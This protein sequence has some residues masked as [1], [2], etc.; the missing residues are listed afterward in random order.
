M[1]SKLSYSVKILFFVFCTY[2]TFYAKAQTPFNVDWACRMDNRPGMVSNNVQ[3][4]NSDIMDHGMRIE[5]IVCD[6]SRPYLYVIENSNLATGVMPAPLPSTAIAP[7]VAIF[8]D[9]SN[10][11]NVFYMHVVYYNT[12][13]NAYQ[14]DVFQYSYG[15]SIPPTL[16][17]PTQTI[18]G[19]PYAAPPHIDVA[20]GGERGAIT[21]EDNGRIYASLCNVSTVGFVPSTLCSIDHGTMPD[22]AV[23]LNGDVVLL[24]Y[25][26]SSTNIRA[27]AIYNPNLI[28]CNGFSMTLNFSGS[29]VNEPRIAIT[30][31]HTGNWS[32]VWLDKNPSNITNSVIGT[33]GTI[34]IANNFI[35]SGVFHDYTDASTWVSPPPSSTNFANCA[36][37]LS[38]SV[39]NPVLSFNNSDELQV[40]FITTEDGAQNRITQSCSRSFGIGVVCDNTG[41]PKGSCYPYAAHQLISYFFGNG[42][43][44][45][46]LAPNTGVTSPEF[47][48]AISMSGKNSMQNEYMSTYFDNVAC[49]LNCTNEVLYK[50]GYDG[51][52]G[53]RQA[54]SNHIAT[55]P[56]MTRLNISPNPFTEN[57]KI[58]STNIDAVC[59]LIITDISGRE[60]LN[61]NGNNEQLNSALLICNAK[62]NA[63]IYFINIKNDSGILLNQKIVKQ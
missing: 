56:S 23:G 14:L 11:S 4:T 37:V 1:T 54:T 53:F 22:V 62:L 47:V 29:Q 18:F 34:D 8:N 33:M 3:I 63:G 42:I 31:N 35:P 24:S 21:I 9:L 41:E 52:S 43:C 44:Q 58:T 32:I 40:G 49:N 59:N 45:N 57:I 17:V 51:S 15:S 16:A 5:A 38:S 46:S 36:S 39:F 6:G 10:G 20:E 19:C 2:Y 48:S 13:V 28:A 27:K 26:T 60:L 55:T 7:D 12:A 50:D 30:A 25:K 61:T